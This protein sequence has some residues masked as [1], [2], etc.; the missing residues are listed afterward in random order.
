MQRRSFLS[1]F[2]VLTALFGAG[3]ATPAI[4][5]AAEGARFEPARHSQDDWLDS[6]PGKHRVVFEI[7]RA[8]V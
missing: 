1:R 3:A 5:A 6:L 2:P 4:A 7:G 8:H